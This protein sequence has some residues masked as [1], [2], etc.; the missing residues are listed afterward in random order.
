M[1]TNDLSYFLSFF[2]V[3]PPDYQPMN[4]V[5]EADGIGVG[6]SPSHHQDFSKPAQGLFP[7]VFNLAADADVTSNATCGQSASDGPE[8]YCRLVEHVYVREPQCGVKS[9]KSEKDFLS[10]LTY[11]CVFKGNSSTTRLGGRQ[12]GR[13]IYIHTRPQESKEKL[14]SAVGS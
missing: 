8:I 4:G 11:L 9:E 13:A 12:R 10:F 3:L 2:L 14:H 1:N 7:S 6:P 5:G